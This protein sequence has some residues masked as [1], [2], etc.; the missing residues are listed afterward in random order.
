MYVVEHGCS[1]EHGSL[2]NMHEQDVHEGR[3]G[4]IALIEPGQVNSEAG[5]FVSAYLDFP[6]IPSFLMDRRQT[7]SVV[8]RQWLDQG[9]E[10]ARIDQARCCP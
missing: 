9:N 7:T 5:F 8:R 10:A 3:K 6:L 1:I 4:H 2:N